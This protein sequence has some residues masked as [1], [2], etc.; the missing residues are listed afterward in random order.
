[1]IKKSLRYKKQMF[2]SCK[3]AFLIDSE[4]QLKYLTECLKGTQYT[5]TAYTGQADLDV[6][7]TPNNLQHM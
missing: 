3:K 5:Y 6:E 2:L 4:Q 7:N 1:M